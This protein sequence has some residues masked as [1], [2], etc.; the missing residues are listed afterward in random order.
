MPILFYFFY[1]SFCSQLY[2]LNYFLWYFTVVLGHTWFPLYY[3][4]STISASLLLLC[5]FCIRLASV[6]LSLCCLCFF[7]FEFC[8]SPT[9]A[10]TPTYLQSALS[11][12][13]SL[14]GSFFVLVSYAALFDKTLILFSPPQKEEKNTQYK[15]QLPLAPATATPRSIQVRCL[16]L[17]PL[18]LSFRIFGSVSQL[19]SIHG[20]NNGG[21]Y[22]KYLPCR[23]WNFD[24][25]LCMTSYLQVDCTPP[26]SPFPAVP[27]MNQFQLE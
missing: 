15:L 9:S 8:G 16:L 20:S 12:C 4:F 18:F 27:K 3:L 24:F 5:S 26:S 22:H 2:A 14:L 6:S 13:L 17:P 10:T 1:T 25:Q 21:K 11:F 23:L 19:E 7:G